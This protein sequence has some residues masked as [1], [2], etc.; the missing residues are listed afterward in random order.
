MVKSRAAIVAGVSLVLSV[1]LITYWYSGA[2]SRARAE[3]EE[4]LGQGIALF[5]S[6]EYENALETLESIPAD[7]VDEWEV[8]YYIGSS[9]LML[10]DYRLAAKS[11]EQALTL[12]HHDAGILYALGVAYYKLGNVKLA[13]AYFASVL[14]INPDDR[15][16]K[17]LMDIMAK[18]EQQSGAPTAGEDSA[19][20]STGEE[21]GESGS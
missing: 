20:A 18:L 19:E 11:L 4:L 1:A 8:P 15:H 7:Q 6:Q 2:D 12:N 10:E 17:G 21:S 9:H 5:E 13:K 14:E 3:R 16:A